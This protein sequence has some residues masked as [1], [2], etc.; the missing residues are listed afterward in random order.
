VPLFEIDRKTKQTKPVPTTTYKALKLWERQDLEEW[1][2]AAPELAGGDFMVVTSEYD[3]FDRSQERVDILGLT[4]VESGIGRLVVVELK[5]EGTSTTVDLQAI[6][7]A[8]YVSAC[9]FSDACDM[10]AADRSIDEQQARQE[11]LSFLDGTEDEP[12][13]IDDTPRIVLL[14]SDFRVEVTTTALWLSENFDDFDIRCVRLTPHE[15]GDHLVV[16]SEVVIPL[17]AAEDY[18]LRIRKKKTEKEQAQRERSKRRLMPRLLE[19]GVI[20]VGQKLYFRAD[21]VPDGAQP[22]WSPDEPMY[23]ASVLGGSGVKTLSWA[24]PD[25]AHEQHESPSMLT[26]RIL[27]HFSGEEN[28]SS[29]GINGYMYWTTDGVTTLNSL[30]AEAG[31]IDRARGRIDREALYE[32]CALIPSGRWTTYGEIAAAIGVPGAAQSVA[33]VIATDDAVENAHRVLRASGRVAPNW[34]SNDGKG[35]EEAS[36]R[37]KTEGIIFDPSGKAG[38]DQHWTPAASG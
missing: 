34:R 1:V 20:K 25:A 13:T 38:E 31:V 32:V 19:T 18:Q 22:Q 7:Y 9:T 30:A 14:A 23:Q 6:K 16:S 26:A 15:I 17:P 10:Y 5:R 33:G 3:A 29:A 28:P 2:K 36:A 12:P 11:L 21:A 27:A 24:Y 37:L 4:K 35:P 8:A